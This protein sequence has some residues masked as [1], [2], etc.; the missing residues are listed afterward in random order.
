MNLNEAMN[1]LS[2]WELRKSAYEMVLS[3][4]GYDQLTGAP[5]QGNDYRNQRLNII[6]TDEKIAEVLKVILESNDT[7]ELTKKKAKLY[8]KDVLEMQKIPQDEYNAFNLASSQSQ[9]QWELSKENNDYASYEP[10]LR[11]MIEY[12]LLFGCL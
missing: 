2:D 11:K 9:Q 5:K 12:R 6:V 7:D 3:I 1:Y 4:C 8:A 10:H